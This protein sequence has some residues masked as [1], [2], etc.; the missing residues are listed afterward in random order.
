MRKIKAGILGATGMVGQRL[1]VLLADHPWFDLTTL[2][3]SDNSAGKKYE[4][5][6][7]WKLSVPMPDNVKN[8]TVASCKPD[9]DARIV[10]SAASSKA[11]EIF[12]GQF[13]Q[14]GYAVVSNA[15]ANRMKQDVPLIIP[16]IN[17]GHLD[18]ITVQKTN[19]NRHGYIITNPNCSS[20]P[21]AVVLD[22]LVE[23][24]GVELVQVTTLQALSGAGYPGVASMDM[25][26]NV[27]PFINNEEG[28]IESEPLKILGDC[29]H[30]RIEPCNFA[31]SAQVHRVPVRDGHMLSVSVKLQDK[32][33]VKD[34]IHALEFYKGKISGLNL[35]TS[36]EKPIYVKHEPDRPQPVLDRDNGSG[37]GIT[38]GR[39]RECPVFDI[40][41]S[42]LGHNTIRGAAGAAVLN[43]ELLAA[44]NLV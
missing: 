20:I 31:I 34:V 15:G 9:I 32:A 5:A 21:L 38:V 6:C 41:M 25:L 19:R 10:F 24:W 11:A 2:A 29:R 43:G 3:A 28:K 40:K 36:P 44:K 23:N 4:E 42:V 7:N 33:E 8:K 12:E 22:P 13:A 37:M 14:E 30:D 16:E 35:P 27:V 1:A 18:L 26:D 17:P 39:I